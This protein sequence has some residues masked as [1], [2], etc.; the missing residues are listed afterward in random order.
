MVSVHCREEMYASAFQPVSA[1]RGRDSVALEREIVIKELIAEVAHREA[2][3]HHSVPT[4]SGTSAAG[5]SSC[6][7]MGSSSQRAKLSGSR[8]GTGWFVEPD[9]IAD[10]NLIGP[11]DDRFRCPTG[12]SCCLE[13]RKTQGGFF[14][15]SASRLRFLFDSRFVDVSRPYLEPEAGGRK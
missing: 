4:K 15:R 3:R 9:P 2:W 10:Q 13:V 5:D 12:N 7:N 8:G 11:D 6:Q 14:R 1:D